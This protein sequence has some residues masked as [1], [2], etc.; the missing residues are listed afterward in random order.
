MEKRAEFERV[1]KKTRETMDDKKK[2]NLLVV[3]LL[4]VNDEYTRH[5]RKVIIIC[6]LWKIKHYPSNLHL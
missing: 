4:F 6:Y 3:N 1:K 2:S 5:A